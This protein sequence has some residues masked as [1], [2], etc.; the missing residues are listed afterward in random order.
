MNETGQ[1]AGNA[2]NQ[3]QEGAGGVLNQTGEAISNATGS[4][5]EGVKD[6]LE[7]MDKNN[8]FIF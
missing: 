8:S 6:P 5:V 4:T 7:V 2:T 1:A 3:A